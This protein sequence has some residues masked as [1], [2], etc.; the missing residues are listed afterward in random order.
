M[1]QSSFETLQPEATSNWNAEFFNME[2]E[3]IEMSSI[4]D[5]FSIFESI[6]NNCMFGDI[7][8]RDGTGF[9]EAQ[10]IVGSG[11]E[12]ILFE[13]LTDNQTMGTSA[14]LEKEFRISSISGGS[15]NDKFTTYHIGVTSPYLFVNNQKKISR[16]FLK[17][18]ASEIVDYVGVKILK[19]GTLGGIAKEWTELKT[20][21]SLH[22]KNTVVPNW[23]PFQLINFLAKNSVSADGA[24]NYLFFENNDGFKFMT[25]DEMKLEE[26]KRVL[27]LKD[28]PVKVQ[29][30]GKGI[31]V[32]GSMM[33]KYQEVQRFN[34]P[35]AQTSGSYASSILTHNI[36]QKK[37]DKYTVEYDGE[38]DKVLA[39]GI[40]YNGPPGK[41][42]KD[43][44]VDQHTGFMSAN[45]LYDIHD[46]GEKSHYP[47][48]D[49][50]RTELRN[51][52]VK[53]DIPGDS[54]I[55]AGDVVILRIPTQLRQGKISEDQYS[56]GAWLVTAIHHKINNDGY[57]MTL[58][59][60]KDGFFS[61]PAIT[62]PSRA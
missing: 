56:T 45:Y 4:I 46:K 8:L 53:F 42:F 51:T 14:N 21:P 60:M 10:G 38:A 1:A 29:Q 22:E 39:E 23:N 17:M 52:V 2:G 11:E 31:S 44:N 37:L 34:I 32:D 48:Y 54:N 7:L 3:G 28:M 43:Y 18:T 41:P 50:K 55:F 61:D 36:L 35:L 59:C 57:W 13:I 47:L 33:E 49:M 30:H 5:Q 40:G 6:Y 58:E 62:I 20:T 12:K 26:P 27:T 24:S 19:F 25:V 16:S 15:R 9:V